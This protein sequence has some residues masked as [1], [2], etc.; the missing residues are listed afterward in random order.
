MVIT[1]NALWYD[2]RKWFAYYP[3]KTEDEIWV[4]LETVERKLTE[5]R[6]SNVQPSSWTIYRRLK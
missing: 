3:V 6:I 2:W 5:A 1:K 4:W